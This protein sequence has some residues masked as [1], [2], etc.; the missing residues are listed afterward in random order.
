MAIHYPLAT[1]SNCELDAIAMNV[2]CINSKLITDPTD[3]VKIWLEH[4]CL[5][6]CILSSISI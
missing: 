2:F 3:Q 1:T 6:L 5:S 4:N